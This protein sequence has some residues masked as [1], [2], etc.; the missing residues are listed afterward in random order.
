MT[1]T[2]AQI[3][4]TNLG[5]GII[6]CGVISPFYLDALPREPRLSLAGLCDREPE[7]LAGPRSAGVPTYLDYRLLLG[8]RDLD[9]VI[10]NLPNHIHFPV[11]RAALL[12]GK[13]V[14]CEKPLTLSVAEAEELHQLAAARGLVVHTAFHRRYNRNFLSGLTKVPSLDQVKAVSARYLESIRDHAGADCWYLEPDYS[15][16]GCIADNGPNIYD[17]LSH[18][19]GRLTVT[20]ARLGLD[21]RGIDMSAQVELRNDLGIPVSVQLDWAF[22]GEDKRIEIFLKDG[23]TI[24]IDFL[25]GFPEFKSSLRHEYEGVLMAFADAVV[26]GQSDTAGIDAVRLVDE[27]YA[28][29]R[30]P[31]GAQ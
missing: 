23:S 14:C 11:A 10:I 18:F 16:G 25:T 21:Q 17:A 27:S 29:A 3:A 24:S 6:G 26:A 5:V 12:A 2:N 31:G 19:L 9:A 1:M 4:T 13:H 15:G 30:K 20:G 7:R 28:L 22:P 8:E